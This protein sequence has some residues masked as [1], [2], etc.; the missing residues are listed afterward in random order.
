MIRTRGILVAAVFAA[1]PSF[2]QVPADIAPK[3]VA[4]GRNVLPGGHGRAVPAFSA[5]CSL[6]PALR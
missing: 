5:D 2:S 4:M 1:T 6:T 3:L